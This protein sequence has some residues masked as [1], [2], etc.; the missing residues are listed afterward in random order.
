MEERNGR[1]L[2]LSERRTWGDLFEAWTF[3]KAKAPAPLVA[4]LPGIGPKDTERMEVGP[5]CSIHRQQGEPAYSAAWVRIQPAAWAELLERRGV[6]GIEHERMHFEV[7]VYDER[8]ALVILSHGVI[9]GS[10]WLS[11]IDASTVPVPLPRWRVTFTGRKVG[12]I[13]IFHD[14]MVEVEAPTE[15]AARHALYQTHEHISG[16]RFERVRS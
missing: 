3:D 10:A 13:G 11:M 4:N 15:E 2:Y 16:A 14:C 5:Y 1:P 12:A 9:I 7:I 6:L 8:E